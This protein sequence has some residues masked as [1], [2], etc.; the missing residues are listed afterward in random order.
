MTLPEDKIWANI[1]CLLCKFKFE[2]VTE[3][4]YKF[5][6]ILNTHYKLVFDTSTYPWHCDVL[7]FSNKI[8]SGHPTGAI[9][10]LNYLRKKDKEKAQQCTENH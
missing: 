3:K 1:E 6:A 5:I 4:E 7:Q 9:L 8:Y 10:C 2:F